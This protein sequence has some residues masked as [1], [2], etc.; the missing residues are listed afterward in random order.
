MIPIVWFSNLLKQ[1]IESHLFKDKPESY[2]WFVQR[3]G[4]IK[5]LT[6]PAFKIRFKRLCERVGINKRIYFHLLR[7][8]RLTELAKEFPEQVLKQIAGWNPDS[9]MARTYIHLS[10]KDIE[11]NIL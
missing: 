11:A 9:K 1:F 8:S 7:H 5:P 3:S 10:Q 2:V 4:M 6:Y